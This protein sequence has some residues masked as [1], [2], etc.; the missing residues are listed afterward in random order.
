MKKRKLLAPFL[1]LTAGAAVSIAMFIYEYEL[2]E[3]M[4][5]LILV[6]VTFFIIGAM[7]ARMLDRFDRQN[8]KAASESEGEVIEKDQE[9]G[10]DE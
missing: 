2:R 8:E 10:E 4:G 3:M 1:M 6:L 9:P 7:I 5:I